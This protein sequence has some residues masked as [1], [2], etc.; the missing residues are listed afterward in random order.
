MEEAVVK[1][2]MSRSLLILAV[3]ALL[4]PAAFAQNSLAVNNAAALNGTSFGL[5]VSLDGSTNSVFV[6]ESDLTN[7][8]TVYRG[9]F[10]LDPNSLSMAAGSR[11]AA[12]VIRTD[13]GGN[14]GRLQLNRNAA[15]TSY[16]VRYQHRNAAGDYVGTRLGGNGTKFISIGD[17]PVLVTFEATIGGGGVGFIQITVD[18]NGTVTTHERGPFGNAA[19]GDIDAVRAGARGTSAALNGS[20]YFDEFE[21]FRTLA[22]S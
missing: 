6:E 9:Q 21:S 10:W 13:G 18:D 16:R 4:A 17:N 3:A 7:D 12:I 15:D 8:E 5:E 22:G 14:I 19:N 2:I 1:N 20:Y 11:F